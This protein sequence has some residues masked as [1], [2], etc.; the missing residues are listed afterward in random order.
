MVRFY[1]GIIV[2]MPDMSMMAYLEAIGLA[3]FLKEKESDVYKKLLL[4]DIREYVN[5]GYFFNRPELRNELTAIYKKQGLDRAVTVFY[6]WLE[7]GLLYLGKNSKGMNLTE[8][9]VIRH[10]RYNC[11]D[12]Y[13]KVRMFNRK[14]HTK[15]KELGK[16]DVKL[17]DGRTLQQAIHAIDENLER[18]EKPME[19]DKLKVV[20][21]AVVG[22][23]DV[24]EKK[25]EEPVELPPVESTYPDG[26][27]AL[28]YNGY[29][30]RVVN[31]NYNTDSR[32]NE[33]R[34]SRLHVS[35]EVINAF[36]RECRQ[37]NESYQHSKGKSRGRITLYKNRD[38]VLKW[39][40]YMIDTWN[41]RYNDNVPY[42]AFAPSDYDLTRGL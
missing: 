34:W 7:E 41:A 20:D 16:L 14:L 1:E 18:L 38:R 8:R 35:R 29:E 11:D 27:L 4:V 25:E 36:E 17:D 2:K 39:K 33:D 19:R 5:R 3:K 23:K 10:V 21:T 12:N 31:R 30:I 22:V 13:R 40:R 15:L 9:E 6:G 24:I 32:L 26:D 28:W 37:G 42:D